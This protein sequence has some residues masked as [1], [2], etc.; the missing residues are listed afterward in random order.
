MEES[1]AQIISFTPEEAR[2]ALLEHANKKKKIE[3][4]HGF[5]IRVGEG[6]VHLLLFGAALQTLSNIPVAGNA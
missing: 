2:D 6:K 4:F 5:E 3:P 1:R